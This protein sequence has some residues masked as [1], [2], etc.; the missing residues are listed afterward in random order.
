MVQSGPSTAKLKN[1]T[2]TYSRED[3]DKPVHLCNR[4]VKDSSDCIHRLVLSSHPFI[5]TPGIKEYHH[6]NLFM[7]SVNNKDIGQL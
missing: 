6:A 5:L 4:P 7:S 1:D 3:T 2:C